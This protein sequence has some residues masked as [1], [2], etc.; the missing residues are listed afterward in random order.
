MKKQYGVDPVLEIGENV[1]TDFNVSREDD[2][3]AM[4][5]AKNAA[6]AGERTAGERD[7]A[8]HH[9]AEEGATPSSQSRATTLKALARL[10]TVLPQGEAAR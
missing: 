9:P 5:F 10:L 2:V 1:A 4:M 3:F 6:A 7:H 8:L